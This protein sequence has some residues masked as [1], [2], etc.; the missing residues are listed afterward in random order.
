MAVIDSSG[1]AAWE[2]S[3]SRSSDDP[4][5]TNAVLSMDGSNHVVAANTSACD[6]FG[7]RPDEMIGRAL[8]TLLSVGV[9]VR[10]GGGDREGPTP[11]SDDHSAGPIG[12][13]IVGRR[14]DGSEFPADVTFESAWIDDGPMLSALVRED[15][16][17]SDEGTSPGERIEQLQALLQ[18]ASDGVIVTDDLGTISYASPLLE[19]LQGVEP[20]GLVGVN[21]AEFLHTDDFEA[22]L[23]RFRQ[24]RGSSRQVMRHECR[25]RKADGQWM[26][27]EATTSL[28]EDPR[29]GGLVTN[30]RDVTEQRTARLRRVAIAEFGLMAIRTT[31]LAQL[32]E[33]ATEI[34]FELLQPG[35]AAVLERLDTGQDQ[36]IIRSWTGGSQDFTGLTVP[37]PPTSPVGQI[38]AGRGH[39]RVDNY[40]DE[41]WFI[42]KEAIESAGFKS[43]LG[44]AIGG[45]GAPWGVLRALSRQPDAFD[46]ADVSFA[47]A[48]ANVLASAIERAR[49]DAERAQQ[50]ICD[51]LTGLPNRI[52]LYDR[53]AWALAGAARTPGERVAA[54]FV[55]VDNFKLVNDALGHGAGD[56][57]L[58]EIARRLTQSVRAEDTV[59]RI[60]GDEFV[61]LTSQRLGSD[62]A[63]TLAERVIAS[64]QEPC[65]VGGGDLFVSVRVGVAVSPDKPL[66]AAELLQ[67]AD[68]AMYEAKRLGR[69]CC[70]TYHDELRPPLLA[71]A[72]LEQDLHHALE[73][74]ELVLHF[75]PVVNSDTGRKVGCEALLR[76]DHPE[77]GLVSPGEFIPIMEET[78]MIVP[79]GRWVIEQACLQVASW[80]READHP[81]L[82][83]SVNVSPRQ[84]DDPEIIPCIQKALANSGLHPSSLSIELTE[85]TVIRDLERAKST[86]EMIASL[87]VKVMIDDFG[88]GYSSLSYLKRLPVAMIKI[89][90]SFV[91]SICEDPADQ[92]IVRSITGLAQ[93][94]GLYTVAEGVET[95]EQLDMVRGLGCRLIQGYYFSRPLSASEF[96]SEWLSAS[97]V[98]TSG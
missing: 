22:S 11:G 27:V 2:A 29:V 54:L 74:D 10:E 12:Q 9:C 83:V 25:L 46:E 56:E 17:R 26:W 52:L 36:V 63:R 91:T 18:H 81:D 88:T 50:A 77:R 38:L 8:D 73:R 90:R 37:A 79:V 55:D 57:L 31:S 89:D 64:F 35:A 21:V 19:H 41:P 30:F 33:R 97:H 67:C 23:R 94:L 68:V 32:T 43:S 42:G 59:A 16:E 15:L 70:I 40:D 78:G 66:G 82:S 60:G 80:Q 53:M 76:W 7:Y 72:T 3:G 13:A 45:D 5:S 92:A 95:A 86:V 44:V 48:V 71:R 84:L 6:M 14:C 69:N 96:A 65:R 51:P 85:T 20:G 75:Q 62:Y 47:Q 87:G 1:E 24:E 28:V 39:Q 4:N 93:D 61:I 49:I 58:I 34:M 98:V